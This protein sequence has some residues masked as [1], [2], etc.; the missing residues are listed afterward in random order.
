MTDQKEIMMA[1]ATAGSEKQWNEICDKVKAGHNGG[2]P[3]W[4]YEKVVK[5]NLARA[6]ASL[7][8]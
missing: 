8:G 1:L 7:W 4:W 3:E 6:V 2:Y 5:S